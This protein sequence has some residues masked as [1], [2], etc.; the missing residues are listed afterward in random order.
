MGHEPEHATENREDDE[1]PGDRRARDVVEPEGGEACGEV[2]DC[3]RP[4]HD[5]CQASEEGQRPE[6]HDQGRHADPG[7]EQSVEQPTQRSNHE[8]HRD[9]DLER[10]PHRPE[11][12]EDGPR[13]SD[14][15]L[16]RQVDL[17]GDDDQGH[18]QG[19][20]RDFHLRADEVREVG[21]RQEELRK[22]G[23]LDNEERE[24]EEQEGFPAQERGDALERRAPLA[25]RLGATRR[26]AGIG[27]A[28]IGDE[29]GRPGHR[30]ARSAAS[31][32]SRFA[33]IA[34]ALTA[35]RI[36]AP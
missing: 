9:A 29:A 4:E 27:R 24:D 15:R 36:T 34:S 32:R 20:D 1:R 25:D 18:G 14:H 33:M 30:S 3:V 23:A 6:R 31:R 16:D 11:P 22:A 7:H 13:Q 35:T 5:V 26:R 19:D 28:G 2:A 17:A 8:H 10:D 21:A 12:A